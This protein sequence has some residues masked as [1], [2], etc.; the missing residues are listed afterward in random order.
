MPS[1]S[2]FTLQFGDP[3]ICLETLHIHLF[4]CI[5]HT[6]GFPDISAL[7]SY[8]IRIFMKFAEKSLQ[9]QFEGK[10]TTSQSQPYETCI[11]ST[12]RIDANDHG[13]HEEVE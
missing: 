1:P 12:F 5:P 10:I 9:Q 7:D 6:S 3:A 2:S 11:R 13:F 8:S 4:L